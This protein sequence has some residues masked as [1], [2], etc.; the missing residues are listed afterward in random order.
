ML[1]ESA[2]AANIDF[3]EGSRQRRHRLLDHPSIAAARRHVAVAELVGDDDVLLRPQG[4]NRLVAAFAFE[5]VFGAALARS[6]HRRVDVERRRAHRLAALQIE[7]QL[8]IGGGQAQERRAFRRHGRLALMQERQ[9]VLMKAGQKVARRLGRRQLV[10]KQRSQRR[11]L[12]ETIEVLAALAPGR[13]QR[14][15]ALHH[16]RRRQSA[17]ARLHLHPIVDYRRRSGLAERLNQA[18]N[19]SPRRDQTRLQRIVNLETQ[20]LPSHRAS[21]PPNR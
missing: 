8:P 6:D 15:Q 3:V 10:A 11:V 4:Q 19:A 13:P 21:L 7:D 17:L 12:S 5:R 9:I 18:W 1:I 16:L 2:V 20:P 14:Q